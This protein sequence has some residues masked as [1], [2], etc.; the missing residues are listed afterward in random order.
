MARIRTD[1]VRH[2]VFATDYYPNLQSVS[3]FDGGFGHRFLWCSSGEY[4]GVNVADLAGLRESIKVPKFFKRTE[5]AV[6]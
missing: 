6:L 2:K 1:S 3:H 5:I 4:A